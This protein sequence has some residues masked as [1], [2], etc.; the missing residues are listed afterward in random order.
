M[1]YK[2][3][4]LTCCPYAFEFQCNTTSE[5]HVRVCAFLNQI[6]T[7]MSSSTPHS[8]SNSKPAQV[9]YSTLEEIIQNEA[10]LV[11]QA[12]EALPHSFDACTYALGPVRQATYW[13]KTCADPRGI[14]SACS[15]ACHGGKGPRLIVR[16]HVGLTPSNP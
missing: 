5:Q 16:P 14:C 9:S 10:N 2:S 15:V 1:R 4:R 11:Q 8:S 12:S 6:L 13:C 7:K 3:I